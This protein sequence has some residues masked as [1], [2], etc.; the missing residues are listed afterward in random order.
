MSLNSSIK[1]YGS[2]GSP[3]SLFF[4]VQRQSH[5]RIFTIISGPSQLQSKRFFWQKPTNLEKNLSTQK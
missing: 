4:T 3:R 1:L 2:V 5:S